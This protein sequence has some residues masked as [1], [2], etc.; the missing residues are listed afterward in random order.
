MCVTCLSACRACDLKDGSLIPVA[1][2]AKLRRLRMVIC[3]G[4]TIV[5]LRKFLRAS[6]QGASLFVRIKNCGIP[7]DDAMWACIHLK[8]THGS[9]RVPW[10]EASEGTDSDADY[11]SD[12]YDSGDD[13]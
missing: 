12:D 4:L 10:V 13:D 3:D 2:L 5:M 1:A 8:D 6:V 7:H 9:S 11:S